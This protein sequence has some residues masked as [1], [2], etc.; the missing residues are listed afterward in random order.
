MLSKFCACVF[1]FVGETVLGRN[2]TETKVLEAKLE[3]LEKDKLMLER[4]YFWRQRQFL[5][6]KAF[7]KERRLK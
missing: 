6:A 1:L 2:T 4:D 7:D 5:I 3:Q